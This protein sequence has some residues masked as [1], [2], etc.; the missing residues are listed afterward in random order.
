MSLAVAEVI[1]RVANGVAELPQDQ[2][3]AC[4]GADNPFVSWHFL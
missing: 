2:W 1:A 4:A 3:D